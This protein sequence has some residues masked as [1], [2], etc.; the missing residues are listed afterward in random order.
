[1]ERALIEPE[2]IPAGSESYSG[3]DQPDGE[4]QLASRRAG[5]V[6]ISRFPREQAGRCSLTWT[7]KSEN[8]VGLTVW[9]V[10]RVLQPGETLS[11]RAD[12]GTDVR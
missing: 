8:R 5:P 12:Y 10:N 2:K 4:W 11:L 7:A 1:V 3:A 6:M 9:S